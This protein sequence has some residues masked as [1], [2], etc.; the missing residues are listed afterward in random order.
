MKTAALVLFSALCW[1]TDP[2]LNYTRWGQFGPQQVFPGYT[3][4]FTMRPVYSITF[5]CSTDNTCFSADYTPDGSEQFLPSDVGLTAG[6]LQAQSYGG[7]VPLYYAVNIGTAGNAAGHFNLIMMAGG[8]PGVGTAFKETS[9]LASAGTT[10]STVPSCLDGTYPNVG[11]TNQNFGLRFSG[12]GATRTA[13]FQVTVAGGVISNSPP[14]GMIDGGG[15][16][17]SVP[18]S[19]S[20]TCMTTTGDLTGTAFPVTYAGGQLRT[21]IPI[22]ASGNVTMFVRTCSSCNTVGKPGYSPWM[23][24]VHGKNWPT[25]TTM[26]YWAVDTG[27]NI[28]YPQSGVPTMACAAGTTACSFRFGLITVV[29]EV[30]IPA[31]ALPVGTPSQTIN[32]GWTFCQDAALT[33][34]GCVDM[35]KQITVMQVPTYTLAPPSPYPLPALFSSTT[36]VPCQSYYGSGPPSGYGPATP[37]TDCRFVSLLTDTNQR[38]YGFWWPKRTAVPPN[39]VD[40]SMD[41]NSPRVFQC[42][43]TGC[44]QAA[45]LQAIWF[46]DWGGTETAIYNWTADSSWLNPARAVQARYGQNGLGAPGYTPTSGPGTTDY[47]LAMRPYETKGSPTDPAGTTAFNTSQMYAAGGARAAA[48]HL[49]YFNNGNYSDDTVPKRNWN[50]QMIAVLYGLST[51]NGNPAP[52]PF[53]SNGVVVPGTGAGTASPGVIGLG[54]PGATNGVRYP[55]FQFDIKLEMARTLGLLNNSKATVNPNFA[56]AYQ[57]CREQMWTMGLQ[58]LLPAVSGPYDQGPSGDQ[59]WMIGAFYARSLIHDYEFSHDPLD[60]YILKGVLDYLKSF[61]NTS[62]NSFPI[63]IGPEGMNCIGGAAGRPGI[64]WYITDGAIAQPCSDDLI[65]FSFGYI[66][67]NGFISAPYAW[68]WA[69]Y[70]GSDNSYADFADLMATEG[71]AVSAAGGWRS[72]AKAMGEE[73]GWSGFTYYT[74]RQLR[75]SSPR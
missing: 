3:L 12:S 44:T 56:L 36:P 70:G 24:D 50:A 33:P 67:L 39:T 60:L 57:L 41:L 75:Q 62:T 30:T 34:S 29:A 45:N 1:A 5:S 64:G 4:L 20:L 69:R 74:E 26:K 38:G 40:N 43:G 47:A 54:S 2:T 7:S 51:S 17:T 46:Y 6:G 8:A 14:P 21:Y 16:F 32:A 52:V 9:Y 58:F 28:L 27:G 35:L 63:M 15:N 11:S 22:T 31:N 13:R 61:Y 49:P 53:G 10:S 37:G 59:F 71:V 66:A 18:T 25:G 68:W 19:G 23:A 72:L 42:Y 55:A 73:M 65:N 48:E